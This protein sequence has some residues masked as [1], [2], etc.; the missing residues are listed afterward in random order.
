[1]RQ[2][3]TLTILLLITCFLGYAQSGTIAGKVQDKEVNN[4]P[5][6]FAN[7]SIKGTTKGTT[8]DFDGLYQIPNVEPG[9]YTLVFSFV[10]YETKEIPNVVV[11]PGKIT[12]VDVILGANAASLDAVVI[13]T[14]TRKVSEAALLLEQKKAKSQVYYDLCLWLSS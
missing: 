3:I 9:T 12:T 1:M 8:S 13:T 14:T 2:K 5:L 4:D 10:G 11:N 6:P 7:I